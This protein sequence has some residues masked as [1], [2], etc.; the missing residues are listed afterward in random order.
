MIALV[1]SSDEEYRFLVSSF[2]SPMHAI[3]ITTACDPNDQYA[4]ILIVSNCVSSGFKFN[5]PLIL[6]S[7][8]PSLQ[9]RVSYMH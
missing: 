6:L 9:H 8:Y 7:V 1:C 3:I 5:Y 2:I 4:N